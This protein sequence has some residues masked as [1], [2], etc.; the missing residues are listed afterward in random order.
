M[1][2]TPPGTSAVAIAS[3]KVMAGTGHRSEASTTAVFPDTITGANRDTR[4]SRAGSSG[5]ITPTTPVGSAVEI[6][7]NGPATGFRFPTT[8]WYLSAHPA[9]Q[10]RRSTARATSRRARPAPAPVARRC[11]A[12]VGARSS[13]ISAIRYRI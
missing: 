12:K 9:Y 10:T 5:A 3:E 6:L 7:K 8:C 11:S 4:P 2:T 13:T 1:F